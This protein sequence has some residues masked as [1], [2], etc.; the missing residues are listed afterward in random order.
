MPAVGVYLVKFCSMARMAARLM[1]SGVG[2]SGSPGPKSTTSMPRALYRSASVRTARV[3]ETEMRLMRSAS[4][5]LVSLL[6]GH[7]GPQPLFDHGRH[8]IAHGP[9]QQRN[10]ADQPRTQIAVRLGGHHENTAER[11]EQKVFA[12]GVHRLLR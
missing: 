2:K 1:C 5:T 12:L 10:L 9:A 4:C 6:L 11:R 7:L 8:Q 3:G